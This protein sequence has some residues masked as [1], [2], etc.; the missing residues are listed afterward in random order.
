M[1]KMLST[2]EVAAFLG[3]NEKNVYTLVADKGLPGAKVTGKWLFPLHLV[4]Q[5]VEANTLNHPD[6]RPKNLSD[7]L[8]VIAGSNDPLL[9]KTISLFN[10]NSPD[11]LAVFG[12]VGS[13]G[14]LSALAENQC[15]IAA[16]HLVQNDD[17]D[18]NFA[19]AG[20]TLPAMPAVI[21]FCKRQQVIIVAKGNPKNIQSVGDLAKRGVTI[22]NR[23]TATGTRRLLDLKLAEA[24][25]EA[26]RIAG[27]D[28]V[29]DRHIDVGLEVFS[30]NADA[31]M[32]IKMVAQT[33]GLDFIPVAWERYDLL[34]SKAIFFDKAVQ[35]FCGLLSEDEFAVMAQSLGGYDVS[36][37]GRIVFPEQ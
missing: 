6:P 36:I 34:V 25:V 19:F 11:C 24:S 23:S 15:H 2:K 21:N 30:G 28:T 29:V 9:E 26:D 20:E 5:W 8:L 33:L 27:Y 10:R 32:A 17:G 13:M 1:K 16:S 18:Y 3:I 12:N 7:K 37:S 22:V 35:Y 14:G 31:G 4:E